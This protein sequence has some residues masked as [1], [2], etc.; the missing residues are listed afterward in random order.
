M[1]YCEKCGKEVE[2]S[3]ESYNSE[4]EYNNNIYKYRAFRGF[5]PQCNSLIEKN[6][7]QNIA[8]KEDAIRRAMES[9]S[10]M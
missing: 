8:S 2:P 9:S 7:I 4:F 1:V 5:C 3:L 10:H 6:P